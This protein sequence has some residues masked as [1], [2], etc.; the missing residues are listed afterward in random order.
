MLPYKPYKLIKRNNY[1]AKVNY[2]IKRRVWRD[3]AG[4][5]TCNIPF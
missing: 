3:V 2:I 5:Y 1:A 4:I